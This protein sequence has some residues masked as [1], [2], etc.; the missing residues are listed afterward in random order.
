[1]ANPQREN[2]YTAIANEILEA[3][4]HI[5]IPGEARQVLDVIIRK[6]W[7]YQKKQDRIAI[8]QLCAGTG[9]KK[10][11]VHKAIGK[12][13]AMNLVTQKGDDK[14]NILGFQKDFEKWV[15]LPKKVTV[16][17]LGTAVT[18]MGS[19]SNPKRLIQKKKETMTKEKEKASQGDAGGIVK[20]IELFKEVNPA[21]RKWFANK[22]QRAAS[23][24]LYDAHGIETLAQVLNLVRKTN[25]MAYFPTITT[26]DQLEN[27]W[28]ALEAAMRK[29]KQELIKGRKG[30]L[31]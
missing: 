6:T 29:K 28:A 16:T 23:Q 25:G 7:G 14:G 17:Q 13:R 11:T 20:V 24:R 3:L 21:Y 12:L 2:G 26:P 15:P 18:N 19:K 9:L 8:S 22:T 30:V 4:G 5:R 1:M 27:K 10:Q 31:I